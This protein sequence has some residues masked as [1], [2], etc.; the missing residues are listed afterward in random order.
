MSSINAIDAVDLR[1]GIE[2]VDGQYLLPP[3]ILEIV[4]PIRISGSS[5]ELKGAVENG[6]LLTTIRR[7][8]VSEDAFFEGPLIEIANCTSGLI[9]D[10]IVDGARFSH[11]SESNGDLRHPLSS[12][13]TTPQFLCG[14][15]VLAPDCHDP[16]LRGSPFNPSVS[17]VHSKCLQ[18]SKV[19]IRNSVSI[20]LA[21]GPYSDDIGI[22]ECQF[23]YAGDY[24]IWIGS[25]LPEDIVLPL[26]S[27][28]FERLP[29]NIKLENCIIEKSGAAG[30]YIDA[31]HCLIKKSYLLQNHFDAPYD[32]ESGQVVIGYKSNNI[33]IIK[34]TILSGSIVKRNN[35]DFSD[36]KFLGTFGIEASGN[37]LVFEDLIISGHYREGIQF[38]GAS[39]VDIVGNGT[40]IVNNHIYDGGESAIENN[41]NISISTTAQ[42]RDLG[43]ISKN[44]NIRDISCENGLVVWKHPSAP[45]LIVE[46][47][48]V[49]NCKF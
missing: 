7:G 10:F 33:K 14:R 39:N 41:P 26:D 28:V 25:G 29:K 34:C 19:Y 18:I 49:E 21:V 15:W 35:I 32:D 6:R 5:V 42:L 45:E 16:A 8:K 22:S 9:S 4:A 11:T 24:G 38:L 30:L 12:D 13:N 3:G 1:N 47:V 23:S 48:V 44:F 27:E 40:R 36:R 46:G 43:A 31:V 20:G 37:G 2:V 17:I